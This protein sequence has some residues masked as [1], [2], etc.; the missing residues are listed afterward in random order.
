MKIGLL[1][2]CLFAV[3]LLAQNLDPA[4]C[5]PYPKNYK[6]IVWNWLQGT[7]LD[8]DSAKIEWQGD[9]KPGDLGIDVPRP[10]G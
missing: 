2:T 7:L 5:G 10:F 6:E 8:A 4:L 3:N 9:P 1:L